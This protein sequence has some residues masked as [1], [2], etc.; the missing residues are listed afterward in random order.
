[1]A[2]ALRLR[3]LTESALDLVFPPQC[4][5]CGQPGMH[6]C[7][8]C[9]Q[10]VEPLPAAICQRCGRPTKAPVA[11]CPTCRQHPHALTFARAA[12]CH[13]YPLREAI[14]AFK[15]QNRPELGEPLGRYLVAV[16]QQPPWPSLSSRIDAVVPAPLHVERMRERGYNQSELLAKTLCE[17]CGLALEP[18][19]LVRT[20]DTLQ[21]VGLSPAERLANVDG[22][23]T[24]NAVVNGRTLLIVDDVFTTGSTLE[25]CARAA[26]EAGAKRVYALALAVPVHI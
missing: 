26:L 2:L 20:R 21:Q 23:F 16:Y 9:A 12:A 7:D 8:R 11:L 3:K 14:H 13:T 17:K 18:G 19:W 22:A 24:A 5:G 10:A 15:Y 25:S 4:A 6:F 1:M